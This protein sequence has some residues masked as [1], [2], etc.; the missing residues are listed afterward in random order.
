MRLLHFVTPVLGGI[1]VC[2]VACSSGVQG[3]CGSYFDTVISYEA[4]C[5]SSLFL[6]SSE[7]SAFEDYCGALAA[8][9][10]VKDLASQIDRCNS[11]LQARDCNAG[12]NCSI[13]GTLADGAACGNSTQCAGGL[14]DGT[15]SS[16]TTEVSCGKCASYLQVGADCS[17][18]T[19]TCDPTTSACV[20]GKCAAFVQKGESCA[21]APCASGLT[22]DLATS[23]CAA[24]P[25]K[26]AACTGECASPYRCVSGTCADAVQENGAC[27]TSGDCAPNLTCSNQTCV[28]PQ[29]AAEGQPC[30]F[31]NNQIVG[32]QTGL[33]CAQESTNAFTCIAPKPSGASCTVGKGECAAFLACVGGTCQLPD[34]STC[35]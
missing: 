34:Y 35:K 14:C 27:T 21:A 31:V 18:G 13:R 3:S 24:L 32:C 1:A 22:C 17:G 4:K 15:Q 2:A 33:K 28:A 6:D 11:A 16:A 5:G 19:G 26:G 25:Q 12:S 20:Q 23:T 30:G 10:G 8:E 9:P 7:K 29:Q